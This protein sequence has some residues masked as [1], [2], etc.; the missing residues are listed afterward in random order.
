MTLAIYM[1]D[2]VNTGI[3]MDIKWFVI[4]TLFF[5]FSG[6]LFKCPTCKQECNTQDMIDNIFFLHNNGTPPPGSHDDGN[7]T[8]EK[9]VRTATW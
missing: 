7:S 5:L 6:N 8:D 3:V 4:G 9:E 1:Q 2:V